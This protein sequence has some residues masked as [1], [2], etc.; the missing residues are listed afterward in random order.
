MKM[1][2]SG[3]IFFALIL[4]TLKPVSLETDEYISDPKYAAYTTV[5]EDLLKEFWPVAIF[6]VISVVSTLRN[7]SKQSK[8]EVNDTQPHVDSR[9]FSEEEM[10]DNFKTPSPAKAESRCSQA[11]KRVFTASVADEVS[12]V[13]A[14][15][16]AAKVSL[17]GKSDVK[18]AFIY[19]EIL[20]RKY[21]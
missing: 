18:K 6:L 14:P 17:K 16:R 11:G 19:S 3:G 7:A 5:M 1:Y 12:D 20:N 4:K 2:F 21:T 10:C 9:V 13:S 15:T 8:Q